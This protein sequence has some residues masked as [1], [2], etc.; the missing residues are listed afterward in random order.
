MEVTHGTN[1]QGRR[2][3]PDLVVAVM[4]AGCMGGWQV[5]H[6]HIEGIADLERKEL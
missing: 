2:R 1:S 4:R 5:L 6:L 3:G